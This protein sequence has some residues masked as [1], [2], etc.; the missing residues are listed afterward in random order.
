MLYSWR[1]RPTRPEG[2]AGRRRR[3]RVLPPPARDL[4]RQRAARQLFERRR[5]QLL[6]VLEGAVTRKV[7]HEARE[8]RRH[9]DAHI[10][11]ARLL[12]DLDRCKHPHW[13]SLPLSA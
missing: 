13:L 3:S 12:R 5:G 6:L 8:L 7:V 11:V 9:E 4:V 10:L 1:Y 2:R